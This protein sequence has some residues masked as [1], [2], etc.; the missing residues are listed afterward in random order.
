ML[1]LHHLLLHAIHAV[2]LVKAILSLVLRILKIVAHS[3]GRVLLLDHTSTLAV[4]EVT[5][6]L[7]RLNSDISVDAVE[8]FLLVRKHGLEFK[9]FSTTVDLLSLIILD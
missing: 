4:L 9:I 3:H 5:L 8:I 2:L 6:L 7:V 1:L